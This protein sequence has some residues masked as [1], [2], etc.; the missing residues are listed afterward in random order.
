MFFKPSFF[1]FLV[2]L[3]VI[4]ISPIDS[5]NKVAAFETVTNEEINSQ[6]KNDYEIT[7]FMSALDRLEETDQYEVKIRWIDLADQSEVGE[8]EVVGKQSSGNFL[9]TINYYP[10]K[11]VPSKTELNIL[12]YQRYDLVYVQLFQLLNSLAF[13]KQPFFNYS[14]NK[15]AKKYNDDYVQIAKQDLNLGNLLKKPVSPF[16]IHPNKDK[17]KKVAKDFLKY[18]KRDPSYHIRM[19][20]IEIPADFF[21]GQKLFNLN[22]KLQINLL[23]AAS[24]DKNLHPW[25][26][27]FQQTLKINEEENLIKFG[28][29]VQSDVSD[30]LLNPQID[31][32]KWIQDFEQSNFLSGQGVM[33]KVTKV[34][35][36]LDPNSLD[37]CLVVEGM[38]E[39]LD[40]NL[41]KEDTAELSTR[42]MRMEYHFTPTDSE[43]PSLDSVSTLSVDEANYYID[44]LIN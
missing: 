2:M 42:H 35:I 5:M 43:V 32:P 10:T 38:V 25:Q 23:E 15:T 9:A 11:F 30:Q 27:E 17:L 29:E 21:E 13:Y 24:N 20:R 6:N 12:S 33:D 44:Q 40:F 18:D 19:D 28:Y 34:E 31:S 41:F 22:Y 1:K 3:L 8:V 37:Y 16:I 4:I 36:S 14:L 26:N 7:E 39:S